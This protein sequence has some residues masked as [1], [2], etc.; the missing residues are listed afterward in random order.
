[1][2]QVQ[3]MMSWLCCI[4]MPW[5]SGSADKCNSRL[6][7]TE[8]KPAA[9]ICQMVIAMPAGPYLGLFTL[10]RGHDAGARHLRKLGAACCPGIDADGLQAIAQLHSLQDLNLQ[11]CLLD[12]VL[13]DL[14][15][16]RFLTGMSC[17]E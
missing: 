11:M 1:M 2:M 14:K 17:L 16:L 5:D 4:T 3:S 13:P 8:A 15:D 6:D 7:I 12:F 10:R 9:E